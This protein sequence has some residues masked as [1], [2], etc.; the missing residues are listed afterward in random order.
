MDRTDVAYLINSTPKYYYI[1]DLHLTMLWRYAPS[2]K[3][4]VYLATEEPLHP[5]IQ[6]LQMKFPALQILPLTTKEESFFDS[7]LAASRKLPPEIRY[8][9]P[10]QDDFLL[11]ARPLE[12]VFKELFEVFDMNPAIH[13]ARLMPCPG[14]HPDNTRFGFTNWKVLSEKDDMLFTYQATVWRRDAYEAYFLSLCKRIEPLAPQEKNRVAIQ[15]NLAE[16]ATG[17]NML[18]AMGGVHL[19]WPR[20]GKQSNAVYLC[21]WPYR[22]TAIVRGRLQDWAVD[23]AGREGVVAS[24]GPSLK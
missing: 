10:M 1:L 24:P 12:A 19:A 4:N 15:D 5:C 13:S 20:E 11:E 6:H 16:I 21:P 22:P 14:P 3:W 2:L 17:Q 23:L 18:R 9:L 7:R 8:V